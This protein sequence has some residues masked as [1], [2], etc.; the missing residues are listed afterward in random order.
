MPQCNRCNDKTDYEWFQDFQDR[1]KLGIKLDINNF[2]PHNCIP[3][4][5]TPNNKRNWISFICEKCGE[6]IKQNIKLVKSK[7]LKLCIECDNMC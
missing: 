2:R 4:N 3:Q 7:E 5:D 1:W 6:K